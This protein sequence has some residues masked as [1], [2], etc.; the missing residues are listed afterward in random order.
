[1]FDEHGLTA[2]GCKLL[3]WRR[4]SIRFSS[5][6]NYFKNNYVSCIISTEKKNK[7]KIFSEKMSLFSK[8]LF[9]FTFTTLDVV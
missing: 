9:S 5:I 7:R 2:S 4:E 1:V 8:G 6:G 3:D